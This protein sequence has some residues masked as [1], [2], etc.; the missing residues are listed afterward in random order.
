MDDTSA[1]ALEGF[2][3]LCD[4]INRAGS[5]DPD[6]IRAALVATDLKP[7]QLM[8]GYNGVKF[9]AQGQNILAS[10]LLVQLQGNDYV[11][12]WPAAEA[13]GQLEL[14]FKGWA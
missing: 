8:I 2:L 6:K 4:A 10:T 12:I 13:T 3:V 5:T 14:P 7:D 1:R 11:P 9:N